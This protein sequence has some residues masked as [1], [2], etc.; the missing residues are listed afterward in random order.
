MLELLRIEI[1]TT[2]ALIGATAIG[3]IDA[4]YVARDDTHFG[5]GSPFPLLDLVDE[6][7]P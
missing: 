4:S 5:G 7:Q 6:M 3:E 1:E 2:M